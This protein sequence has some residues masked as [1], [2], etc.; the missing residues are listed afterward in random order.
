L[1]CFFSDIIN[2]E[3]TNSLSITEISKI[4][5]SFKS[6]LRV[7]TLTGG[8]PY[9]REELPE[10]CSLLSRKNGTKLISIPTNGFFPD[11]IENKTQK[12]LDQLHSRINVHV[13]L[14][15]TKEVHNSLR[16]N[17]SSFDNAI[18]TIKILKKLKK[19]YSKF[20]QIS[21][22][23]TISENNAANITELSEFVKSKL[24]VFH[25]FQF[26]REP[27]EDVFKI[28]IKYI[29]NISKKQLNKPINIDKVIAIMES[30]A[31]PNT[32]NLLL[33]KQNQYFKY[34]AKILTDQKFIMECVAGYQDAVIY[35]NGDVSVCEMLNSFA[36]LADYNYDF[37]RLWNSQAANN[38][39]K[40]S[41]KCFCTHPCSITTS[42]SY[43]PTIL[44]SICE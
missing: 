17:H 2:K 16:N 44:N 19:K 28:D 1:H 26:I 25:K 41:N 39:K 15:G 12:I 9:L 24:D 32:K 27:C 20:N 36:N 34:T 42:I 11:I 5:E 23:T 43:N 21:V 4:I 29:K 3:S 30:L 14:D 13:S 33:K 18:S 38:M 22:I 40:L 31:N 6:V 10:I 8:E 7:V 35:A 37:Y